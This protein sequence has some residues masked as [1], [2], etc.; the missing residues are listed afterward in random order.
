MS[1]FRITAPRGDARVVKA[2]AEL[3]LGHRANECCILRV[4]RF[5]RS[6]QVALPCRCAH[7]S[8]ILFYF[9]HKNHWS[10]ESSF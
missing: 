6:H 2:T 5:P 10:Y 7:N 9:Q 1:I 4:M 3:T 8:R